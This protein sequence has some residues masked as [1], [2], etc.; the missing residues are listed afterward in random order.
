MKTTQA[1]KIQIVHSLLSKLKLMHMKED[2]INSYGVA[3]TK[4]LTLDQLDQ[5]INQLNLQYKEKDA[6][7]KKEVDP[8]VRKWR[9]VNLDLLSRLGVYQ[10]QNSWNRVNEFLLK[11]KIAGME[12]YKMNIEELKKLASKL[13][14]IIHKRDQKNEK[15]D[16]QAMYN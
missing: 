6:Q 9:S 3:S 11:P 14:S 7:I 5:L 4:D 10:N 13:R 8:L 16:Y 1:K 15:E 2:I 12:L